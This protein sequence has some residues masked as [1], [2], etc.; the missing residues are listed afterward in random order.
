MKKCIYNR[1]ETE[2]L[3]AVSNTVWVCWKD[4][5]EEKDK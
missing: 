2:S 5:I 3:K 4:V 1:K